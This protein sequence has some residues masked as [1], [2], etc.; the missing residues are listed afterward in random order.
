MRDLQY[1][2]EESE[3]TDYW[4]S[5]DSEGYRRFVKIG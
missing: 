5:V 1:T 4:N 3:Y 2:D